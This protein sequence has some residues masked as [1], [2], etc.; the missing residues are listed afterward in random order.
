METIKLGS[1]GDSVK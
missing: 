1:K